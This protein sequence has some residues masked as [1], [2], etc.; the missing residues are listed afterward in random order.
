V[1]AIDLVA[2]LRLQ[3]IHD[4]RVLRAIAEVPRDR[5]VPLGLRGAA[6]DDRPLPIG[7]GQT[8]SQPYIVAY[9]LQALVLEGDERVLD[10]GTGSGYQ[11]ALLAK[12]VREVYTVEIVGE[13]LESARERFAELGIGNVQSRRGDGWGGW[14][15]AA[16]FDGIVSASAAPKVPDPLFDQLQ[17]GARLV[18]PVGPFDDQ[19]LVVVRRTAAGTREEERRLPVRFVPMTGEAQR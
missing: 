9:M 13:L 14:P 11:A 12:L 8:I 7:F 2:E 16:P 1:D 18:L 17:S 19:H 10:V 6:W 4:A 3:G 5:F 15:E